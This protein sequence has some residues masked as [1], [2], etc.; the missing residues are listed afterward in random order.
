MNGYELVRLQPQQVKKSGDTITGNLTATGGAKFVGN[1]Q[2]NA[3]TATAA[4][5]LQTARQIN[6][7]NF[8]GTGNIT[9]ANWGTARNITIGN[10]AK[11]VNGSGNV[12]WNLNEIGAAASNHNQASNTITALT[13]YNKGNTTG[14]ISATDNLNTALAKLENGLS[15]GANHTHNYAGS[16]TPGG[17][18][19]SAVQLQ[20][21]RTI[22]GTSFNGTANITTANWGTSRNITIGEATKPINGSGNVTY[23]LNEM[24][25]VRFH[26]DDNVTT[27]GGND[28][29]PG[30]KADNQEWFHT[31]SG[32]ILPL[33]DGSGYI[34]H[35]TRKFY[36]VHTTNLNALHIGGHGN[37]Q[38]WEIIPI[39][40]DAGVME[41]GKYIDFHNSKASAVDYGFRIDNNANG[42]AI[43]FGTWSQF[44]DK[45]V[46]ENIDYIDTHTTLNL[47]KKDYEFIDFIKNM[48]FATYNYKNAEQDTF[49]FIAQDIENHSIS[50]YLLKDC[51]TEAFNDE[52]ANEDGKASYKVF[53]TMA[54]ASVIAKALQEEILLREKLTTELQETMKKVSELEKEIE[55][56]KAQP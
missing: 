52:D 37:N 54:Y 23:T 21:A 9:T 27:P 45:R 10:T 33:R 38:R 2:G 56:L 34:G 6:G 8:D 19:N 26:Y 4:T 14:A 18:A 36:D 49:G 15:N 50:S 28:R 39:V 12:S 35:G 55:A 24:K 13:G 40:N 46:K 41:I 42:S 53:D 11:S 30:I 22:N 1:L 17:A 5:K 29:V 32:G 48:K 3:D 25:A 20:T 7:T 51:E 31:P 16:N 47:N 43:Y 44:S